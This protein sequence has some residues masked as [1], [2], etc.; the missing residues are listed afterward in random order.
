M[1][2]VPIF[3]FSTLGCYRDPGAG[4][5]GSCK[6][7]ACAVVV[8]GSRDVA[9]VG[10]GTTKWFSGFQRRAWSG[11]E[12][13]QRHLS[14]TTH[15]TNSPAITAT[16]GGTVNNYAP[17]SQV[18]QSSHNSRPKLTPISYGL[19]GLGDQLVNVGER[20]ALWLNNDGDT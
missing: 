5:L 4:Y 15:G 19:V 2:N 12:A 17:G 6:P 3:L 16:H 8:H 14:Q 18:L 10:V 20:E 9:F 1:N 11:A 7:L 13:D